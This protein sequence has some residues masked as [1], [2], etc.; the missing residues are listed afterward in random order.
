MVNIIEY[1]ITKEKE[2]ARYNNKL[3]NWYVARCN[4]FY[5]FSNL[6]KRYKNKESKII[7]INNDN[8]YCMYYDKSV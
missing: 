2:Y 8:L 7:H 3:D 1:I 6:Y 5:I 4:I